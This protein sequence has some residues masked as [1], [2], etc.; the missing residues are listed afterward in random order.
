MQEQPVQQEHGTAK[1]KYMEQLGPEPAIQKVEDVIQ[2]NSLKLFNSLRSD[3]KALRLNLA[4][5]L[6][7]SGDPAYNLARY[8]DLQN[9]AYA[10]H[11]QIEDAAQRND[12]QAAWTSMDDLDQ[13][14]REKDRRDPTVTQCIEIAKKNIRDLHE[15]DLHSLNSLLFSQCCNMRAYTEK[16]EKKEQ[17]SR[18]LHA[19]HTASS[20]HLEELDSIDRETDPQWQEQIRR[21]K[22]REVL[23]KIPL[24]EEAESIAGPYDPYKD[25]ERFIRQYGAGAE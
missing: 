17:L 14:Y 4:L 22:E 24:Y 12:L 18:I 25:H 13:I 23:A 11:D 9:K 21:A 20:R 19:M 16:P 10:L 15:E 8:R 6:A 3:P 5:R 1:E 2:Q 7:Q